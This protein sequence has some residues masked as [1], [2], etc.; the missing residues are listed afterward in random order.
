MNNQ[1]VYVD[2]QKQ[3]M[4]CYLEDKMCMTFS[5]SSG[6]NGAGELENSG[7]TPR[8]WHQIKEIIG[9]GFPENAVFVSRNWT[10]EIYSNQLAMKYPDRDF[11]L[12]R[13][14]RIDGLENAR[15]LG[16]GVDSYER[17]IYIH[18]TPD[19]EPMG[20]PKSHGC[21]RMRNKDVIKLASWVQIGT[22]V[23]VDNH[24]FSLRMI[25]K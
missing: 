20:V 23:F 17:Y 11:I 15:N 9:E 1:F 6:L 10:G 19:E 13:I 22:K 21:I 16:K 4:L 5:I 24:L 7:C 2:I 3:Q 8:G 14:I 18:G 25:N 12:S